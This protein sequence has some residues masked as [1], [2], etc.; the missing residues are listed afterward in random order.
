[1]L[2]AALEW[3][4]WQTS[5]KWTAAA[6]VQWQS[7][8]PFPLRPWRLTTDTADLSLHWLVLSR[9]S[10]LAWSRPYAANRLAITGDSLRWVYPNQ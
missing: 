8:F 10:V 9:I 5:A 6:I 7:P 2:D 1:M 3:L 4:T